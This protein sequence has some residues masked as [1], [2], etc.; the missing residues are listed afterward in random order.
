MDSARTSIIIENYL[1][2]YHNLTT[3]VL[4]EVEQFIQDIIDFYTTDQIIESVQKM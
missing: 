2:H 4:S 3:P 1:R